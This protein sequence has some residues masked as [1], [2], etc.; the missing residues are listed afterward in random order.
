MTVYKKIYQEC[1][2]IKIDGS[3]YDIHHLDENRKNNRLENLLMLPKGLHHKYHFYKNKLSNIEPFITDIITVKSYGQG[4]NNQI[5]SVINNFIQVWEECNKWAD[6]KLYLL[7][8]IG[9]IHG[10]EVSN[11]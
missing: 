6:Y 10:I 7:G 5:I 4:Y 9:N 2:G 8:E 11:G 3:L 1:L